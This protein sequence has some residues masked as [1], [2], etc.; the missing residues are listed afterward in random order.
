MINYM[1]TLGYYIT[2]S[3]P[4]TQISPRKRKQSA[5]LPRVVAA[6]TC[7]TNQEYRR[8][9]V[10]KVGRYG[11]RR[12]NIYMMSIVVVAISVYVIGLIFWYS[13]NYSIPINQQQVKLDAI[14]TVAMCGFNANEMVQA[15]RTKGEWQGPIYV[16]TDDPSQEDANLCT[17]VDVRGNHPT[18]LTQPEFEDYKL[19]IQASNPYVWSKWHKTQIF[20]LLPKTIQTIVFMDADM[21][22]KRPLTKTWLP[23]LAPL[24]QDSQ[25]ELTV[26]PERWYSKLPPLFPT[27]NQKK[28]S[29]PGKYNSG[30]M[31]QK[32]KETAPLLKDWSLR[33]VKP[34]FYGRDQGKLTASIESSSLNT[35]ICWLPS[36]WWHL[37][38][39]ADVTDRIWFSI[40]AKATFSHM[41]SAK[42]GKWKERYLQKCDLSNLPDKAP[43][44]EKTNLE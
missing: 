2:R 11:T 19:G 14:V 37:E 38:N 31:L 29:S 25:C 28:K 7:T 10:L 17:P 36:R 13:Q 44:S 40:F 5:Y 42:T 18:F 3:M 33:M 6:A 27:K 30:M 16:I 26:Y 8:G 4:S 24:L 32:R 1:N 9:R 35:K 34:P 22:A 21:M 39:Q 15:L 23:S 41:A 12:C 43:T 20:Q